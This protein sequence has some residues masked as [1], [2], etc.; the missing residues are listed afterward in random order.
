MQYVQLWRSLVGKLLPKGYLYEQV[1]MH[2]GVTCTKLMLCNNKSY[3]KLSFGSDNDWR[4]GVLNICTNCISAQH[5]R[6][7][8]T[9][10]VAKYQ[11]NLW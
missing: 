6:F 11:T 4:R 7:R 5:R 8:T 10:I 1:S 9:Y 3:S 2:S